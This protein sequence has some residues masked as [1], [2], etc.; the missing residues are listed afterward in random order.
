MRRLEPRICEMKRLYVRPESRGHQLGRKLTMY[1]IDEAG[2][3]AHD[4]AVD[5]PRPRR[6]GS[7]DLAALEGSTLRHLLKS[8]GDAAA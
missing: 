3:I 5:I 8:T 2:V 1:L 4:V 7:A 6:R